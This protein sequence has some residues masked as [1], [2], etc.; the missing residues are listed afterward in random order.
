M[1][2]RGTRIAH[3]ITGDMLASSDNVAAIPTAQAAAEGTQC[4]RV[5]ERPRERGTGGTVRVIARENKQKSREKYVRNR[6]WV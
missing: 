6:R 3:R 1:N 2:S 5:F 4:N